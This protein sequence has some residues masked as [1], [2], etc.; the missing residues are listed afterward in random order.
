[1]TYLYLIQCS[2]SSYYKIGISDSPS[3]RL[4]GLQ[5]GCPYELVLI[6]ACA[7]ST[8]SAAKSAESDIHQKLAHFNIHTEWFD[9]TEKQIA[10]IKHDMLLCNE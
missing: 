1:M 3:D 2:D 10:T 9:L 7:L 6:M 4:A 8:R 5:L